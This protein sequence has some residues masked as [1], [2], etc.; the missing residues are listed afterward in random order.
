[1]KLDKQRNDKSVGATIDRVAA[2]YD[3]S[4]AEEEHPGGDPNAPLRLAVLGPQDDLSTI[5][6]DTITDSVVTSGAVFSNANLPRTIQT[7]R[8]VQRDF[9]EYDAQTPTTA[10]KKRWNP[11]GRRENDDEQ[12]QP[13]TPVGVVGVSTMNKDEDGEEKDG[14]TWVSDA[15]PSKKMYLCA[16]IFGCV[17]LLLI[18]GL[19]VAYTTMNGDDND[20][21]TKSVSNQQPE[22]GG[23]NPEDLAALTQAPTDPPDE[24]AL[25]I[26]L[27]LLKENGIPD[28]ESLLGT[29]TP[30]ARAIVWVAADPNFDDYTESRLLQRYVLAVFAFGLEAKDD[31]GNIGPLS[32]VLPK[33]L[34]YNINECD[35]DTTLESEPVCDGFGFYTHL[36]LAEM[37]LLGTFPTEISLLSNS[38]GKFFEIVFF[39]P[40]LLASGGGLCSL[41]N[42]LNMSFVSLQLVYV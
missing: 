13:E 41:F 24:E 1:M 10:K 32:D 29:Q 6:G 5:A 36:E 39:Q 4:A 31:A 14:E 42:F 20:G 33:W 8:P 34:D 15:A 30:Q 40:V 21:G 22:Y 18:I 7:G 2:G 12:T 38:L 11:Y 28:P 9:K 23:F 19:G 35:W 16:G 17:L 3:F 26:L 27:S 37:G 25:A